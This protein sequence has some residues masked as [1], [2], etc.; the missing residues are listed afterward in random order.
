MA[1]SRS[2]GNWRHHPALSLQLDAQ[3][4]GHITPLQRFVQVG[5]H[6]TPRVVNVARHQCLRAAQHHLGTQFLQAEDVAEGYPGMKDI[7]Y[8]QHLHP[9]HLARASRGC[10]RHPARPGSGVHACH[11]QHSRC[12][13]PHGGSGRPPHQG[14]G[15]RITTMST[16]MARMLFTVSTKVS[17][18]LTLRTGRTEVDHI[19]AQPLLGQFEA[20]PRARA[21]LEEEVGDGDIPQRRHFLDRPV[22]DLLEA[23]GRAEDELDVRRAEFA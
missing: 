15:W 2:L 7:A 8:D 19:G 5:F 10:C 18:L 16:F 21:A 17:P 1:Y 23:I 12:V 3:H 11:H 22:P 6:L 9:V 13:H 4:V 20:H 14:S